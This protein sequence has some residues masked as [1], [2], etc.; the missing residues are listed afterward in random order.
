[1]KKA[2]PYL[3]RLLKVAC[4]LLAVLFTVLVLQNY[5]LCRNDQNRVRMNGYYLEDKNSLDMVVI[6]A[7]D[8]YSGYCAALAYKNYG[9]TSYPYATESATA[10]ACLTQL[11][12]VLR[13]QNPKLIIIEINAFLYGENN[14]HNEAHIRKFSDNIPL[15]ENKVEFVNNNLATADQIEYYAPIV[16]YHG[17]WS[18]YPGEARG[19]VS[20]LQQDLRGTSVLKG[21]RTITKKFKPDE[22]VLNGDIVTEDERVKLTPELEVKLREL[23]DYVKSEKL[24]NV[25]FARFPHLI[26]H[27]TLKRVKK[28]NEAGDII[29]SYGFDF[30]N[31]ERGYEE[32]GIDPKTDFYNWDHLNI[33]GSEKFT[34]YLCGLVTQKYGLSETKLTE[35]QKKNWDNSADY[36]DRLYLFADNAI[37]NT[38]VK[39]ILGETYKTMLLLED[40][41]IKKQ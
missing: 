16:K 37:Q 41:K 12:E 33:Y 3:L 14:E 34:D 23:L 17:K 7:S 8:V 30:Y 38:K 18:D 5:V 2:K 13:T 4:F 11:K 29:Q 19:L 27:K 40:I 10:G 22:K 15:N 25:I 31:F 24:D 32:I 28:A 26:Y 35:E 39:Y 36:Y 20:V 9:F 1:M 6:G 21:Y